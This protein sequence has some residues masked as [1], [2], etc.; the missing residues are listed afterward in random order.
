MSCQRTSPA[1]ATMPPT[2][3]P[4]TRTSASERAGEFV[5]RGALPPAATG[6][7]R[8]RSLRYRGRAEESRAQAPT[9]RTPRC[10]SVMQRTSTRPRR[11]QCSRRT[12]ARRRPLPPSRGRGTTRRAAR[13]WLARPPPRSPRS[14]LALAA[15]AACPSARRSFPARASTPPRARCRRPP[16]RTGPTASSWPR[17]T[18]RTPAGERSRAST[19]TFRRRTSTRERSW[20]T[21]ATRW[22]ASA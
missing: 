16:C 5:A 4:S 11:Q 9:T 13:P 17:R 18:S 20:A 22:A 10:A 7:A 15:R 8:A 6:L 14:G 3:R 19:E 2:R 12:P 21:L 1:L